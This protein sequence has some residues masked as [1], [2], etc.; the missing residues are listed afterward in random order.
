MSG[1]ADHGDTVRR[2]TVFA[3][4]AQI[5]TAAFTAGLTFFLV[6]KLGP[7]EY[8]VFALALGV[9]NLVALPADFGI[10]QSAARF[11]AERLGDR[12]AMASVLAGAGRLKVA[13]ALALAV[14]L[15]ALAEP[16][17]AAYGE[18]G[19]TWP[20]RGVA[21]ALAGQSV[22]ALYLAAFIAV[23]RV[24]INV[25]LIV[26][27]SAV[28]TGASIALVLLG[29]G[30]AAAAAGRA[31][32]YTAGAA[33]A[34][35][36]AV[37]VFG[38]RALAFRSPAPQL[39]AL[40]RYGGALLIVDS[41]YSLFSSVDVLV[42]GAFLGSAAVGLYSAPM[43]LC[44]VLHY[45]GLALSNSVSPRVA[46]RRGLVGDMETFSTALRGLIVVQAA[47]V[48]PI[49]VWADPI[50]RL[51]LGD[52]YR[53]SAEILRALAPFVFLQGLGP[54]LSVSVNFLGQA[55]RRVPIALASFAV[56]L[57]A[58]L[59]LVPAIGVVGGAISTS[60]AYAVYVPAHFRLCVRMLGLPAA[61]LLRTLMRAL[62]AAAGMA[63]V[64]ALAGTSEVS[65]LEAIVTLPVGL[66]VFLAVLRLTGETR[67]V[68]RRTPAGD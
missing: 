6:R 39:R 55:R 51:A 17:A 59:V 62:L 3:L 33:F 4:V 41:A 37:R 36:V 8:G 57:G 61:P 10:S 63:G 47:I 53:A 65:V 18:P 42:I 40:V 21:V 9:A 1:R 56:N 60:L 29:G 46:R 27:E 22:M 11:I 32:G 34:I 35:V 20:L 12:G 66:A 31:I 64:L 7:N 43:R 54:L 23:R 14:A 25:R 45:P 38:R 52:S 24:A 2:N 28:E 15:A 26:A 50:A 68:R 30:A 16:I 13:I 19:L 5:A 58:A 44:T 48:A 67:P 49:V